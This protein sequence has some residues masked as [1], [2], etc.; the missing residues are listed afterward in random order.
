MKVAQHFLAS[1]NTIMQQRLV[2]MILLV[3]KKPLVI[4]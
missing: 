4:A 1:M 2:V 3:K